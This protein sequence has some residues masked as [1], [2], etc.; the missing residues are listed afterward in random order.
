MII[1]AAIILFAFNTPTH[2]TKVHLQSLMYF[3]K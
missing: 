3:Y 2:S 1:T